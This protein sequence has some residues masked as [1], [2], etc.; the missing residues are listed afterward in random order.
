MRFD[1]TTFLAPVLIRPLRPRTPDDDAARLIT[2]I[3]I[4]PRLKATHAALDL[5]SVPRPVDQP[6]FTSQH[7]SERRV[8]IALRARG[9]LFNAHNRIS[10]Q[11]S[12]CVRE[13]THHIRRGLRLKDS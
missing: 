6:I 9:Y 10:E 5:G 8:L 11:I 12:A 13:P 2:G 3:S 4:R 7:G 1:D